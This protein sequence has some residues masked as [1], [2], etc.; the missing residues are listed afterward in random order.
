ENLH[1]G[2][3]W[4]GVKGIGKTGE[5]TEDD[6]GINPGPGHLLEPEADVVA[7]GAGPRAEFFAAVGAAYITLAHHTHMIEGG[8]AG[9]EHHVV[10]TALGTEHDALE[11]GGQVLFEQVRG[12]GDVAIVTENKIVHG[13]L[14]EKSGIVSKKSRPAATAIHYPSRG[15]SPGR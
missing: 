4:I 12:F 3:A 5:T 8:V 10:A 1:M 15:I 7:A 14:P 9:A 11:F 6:G 13:G 2:Q